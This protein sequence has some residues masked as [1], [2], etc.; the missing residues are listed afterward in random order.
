MLTGKFIR[1]IQ[2]G[3]PSLDSNSRTDF[4]ERKDVRLRPDVRYQVR[5]SAARAIRKNQRGIVTWSGAKGEHLLKWLRLAT[6]FRITD[7]LT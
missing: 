7:I 6:P 3:A 2:V 1:S 5:L 4:L